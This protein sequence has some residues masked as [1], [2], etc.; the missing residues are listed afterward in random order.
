MS[1]DISNALHLIN[2]HEVGSGAFGK[3]YVGT[4]DDGKTYAVK[5]RYIVAGLGKVQG[6]IHVNE[7][8]AM[9]RFNHPHILKAQVMQR[10]NPLNDNFRQDSAGPLGIVDRGITY[11]ADLIYLIS[12]AAKCSLHDYSLSLKAQV[13][14]VDSEGTRVKDRLREH[15]WQILWALGH[16]HHH[17]FI[18]RDVKPANILAMDHPN[19]EVKI[20]LCDF[21]MI[22]PYIP[23]YESAKAM[24]PEYTPPEILMQDEDVLYSSGVDIWGVGHVLYQLVKGECMIRRG[25]RKGRD[26]DKYILAIEMQYL[27]NGDRIDA[28]I[29]PHIKDEVL[30]D[31]ISLD[32]GDDEVTDLLKHMLDC[33]EKTRWNAM[34]CMGHSLFLSREIPRDLIDPMQDHVIQP[35][36]ITEEMALVFDQKIDGLINAYGFFLGLDILMRVCV[37]KYRGKPKDLAIC[38]YNLGMKYFDKESA[39]IIPLDAEVVKRVEYSIIANHLKGKVY[40]D[41]LYNHVQPTTSNRKRIYNYLMTPSLFTKPQLFPELLEAVQQLLHP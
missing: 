20:T 38:C 31:P 30:Q 1:R 40:R 27:P 12:E 32:M 6:C 10:E 3:V 36:H 23:Y 24:T 37:N 7:I 21:D 41:T 29:E 2:H 26:L 35:Y 22:L 17:G 15:L 16:M 19:D 14:E 11:R 39:R 34:Q 4:G 5:R 33:D 9:C 13:V 8:D 18:H 28:F 25:Q